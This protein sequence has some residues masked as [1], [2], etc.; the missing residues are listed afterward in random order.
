MLVRCGGGIGCSRKNMLGKTVGV[1]KR[2]QCRP[3]HIF[4]MICKTS[5]FRYSRCSKDLNWM[6]VLVG[7]TMNVWMNEGSLCGIGWIIIISAWPHVPPRSSSGAC[8]CHGAM[9]PWCHVYDYWYDICMEYLTRLWA[10]QSMSKCP[11]FSMLV[12]GL[13]PRSLQKLIP[14]KRLDILPM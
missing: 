10:Y 8:L 1:K 9:V 6:D 11:Y 12:A 3:Q 7:C 14:N 2:D 5:S 4:G 13:I